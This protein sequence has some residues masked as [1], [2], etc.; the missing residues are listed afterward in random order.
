MYQ[1][2]CWCL[3]SQGRWPSR[4]DTLN[5]LPQ[6]LCP[7]NHSAPTS[8]VIRPHHHLLK[9]PALK[10]FSS[11]L[12]TQ[13]W[14]LS[15]LPAKPIET[16]NGSPGWAV[17]MASPCSSLLQR[18][19]ERASQLLSQPPN[20]HLPGECVSKLYTQANSSGAKTFLA[21]AH[22]VPTEP[23][24]LLSGIQPAFLSPSPSLCLLCFCGSWS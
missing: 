18:V 20:P 1:H 6:L 24:T 13:E 3:S 21:P 17:H 22:R 9:P 15:C 8:S 4:N 2:L 11:V 19:P 23:C 5:H 10:W 12:V 14:P 7:P 16:S